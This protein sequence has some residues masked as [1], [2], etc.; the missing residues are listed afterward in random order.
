MSLLKGVLFWFVILKVHGNTLIAKR[1]V[2]EV[3]SHS[4]TKGLNAAPV[5]TKFHI[6]STIKFRYARTVVET[7]MKN[8][9]SVAQK[10]SFS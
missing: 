5:I 6:T 1:D 3:Q 4:D 7:R 2:S 9:G 8:P 10:V